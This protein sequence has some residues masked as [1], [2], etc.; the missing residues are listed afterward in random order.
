VEG[1]VL[2]GGLA[3]DLPA[4]MGGDKAKA[5]GFFKR[6]LEID[7]R[8]TGG[9]IELARL[10]ISAKRWPDAQRELQSI[11]DETAATDLPRWTVRDRPRARAMLTELRDRGRIPAAP[12]PA[13]GPSQSP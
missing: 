13:P 6:A 3:A 8:L 11:V 2:A 4:M 7:P 10:Y 5:E 1:L 9:R 12:A